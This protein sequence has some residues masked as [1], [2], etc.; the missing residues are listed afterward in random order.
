MKSLIPT[1]IMR[2]SY[3]PIRSKI[4]SMRL[5]KTLSRVPTVTLAKI[6]HKT[7]WLGRLIAHCFSYPGIRDPKLISFFDRN[8]KSSL[9]RITAEF[10]AEMVNPGRSVMVHVEGTRS[11]TC[12]VPVEKMSGTF[13]DLAIAVGA[14]VVPIRFVGGLPV[15]PLA[16]RI[17]F[18]LG[19]GRQSIWIGRPIAAAELAAM[20]YGERKRVVIEAIN[21]LG[22]SNH[23]ERPLAGD[24]GFAERVAKYQASRPGLDHEHATLHEVLAERS[25]RGVLG[26]A[27]GRLLGAN[28]PASLEDGSPEGPWLAEL[29]RRLLG[30]PSHAGGR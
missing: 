3:Q 10:A 17:E 13:I 29:S 14:P 25:E 19:M 4:P 30:C 20:P 18:P 6:E 23:D 22:P 9:A 16:K 11:K 28:D 5:L 27:A 8:D 12:A 1:G 21:G 24:A 7:T 26:D 15:E 2:R